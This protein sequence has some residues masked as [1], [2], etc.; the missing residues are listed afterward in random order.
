MAESHFSGYWLSYV[1]MNILL[2]NLTD[3]FNGKLEKIVD[4]KKRIEGLES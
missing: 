3:R 4:I 2:S 1:F